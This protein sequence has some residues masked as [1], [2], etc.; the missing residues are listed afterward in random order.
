MIPV[1][2]LHGVGMGVILFKTFTKSL[3]NGSTVLATTP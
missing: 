1:Y 3:A 2:A